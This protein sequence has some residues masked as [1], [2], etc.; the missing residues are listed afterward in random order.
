MQAIARS[1]LILA[2]VAALTACS[3][4][5]TRESTGEYIDDSVITAR[6]KS[7]FVEDK[8]V[9]ALKIGVETFKGNVQLSGFA[10]HPREIQRAGELA[11]NVRGVESV[12]N[13]I[14]LKPN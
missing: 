14:R 3:G 1:T 13:D 7:A 8:E 11:R 2:M 5:A 4:T 10:D 6:V 9:N 12:K